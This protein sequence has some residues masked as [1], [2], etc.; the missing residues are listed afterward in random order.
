MMT[1][2]GKPGTAN[3]ARAGKRPR[4]S[5]SST[6]A[7]ERGKP[8]DVP[9]G[10]GG[11]R[12]IMGAFFSVFNRIEYGLDL[13]HAVDAERI[14]AQN[15]PKGPL[16]VEDAR[17]APAVLSELERRGHALDR[18]GE[19]DIRP[20]V[21]AAGFRTSEER[22][23]DAVS[24]PRTDAGSLAQRARRCRGRLGGRDGRGGRLHDALP[25]AHYVEIDGGRT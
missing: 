11:S 16:I 1:D 7:V 15:E 22:L 21:Q 14:D 17:I 19:Y 12:I 18:K 3:E 24:D 4:S 8:I 25:D 23:K 13:A 2:F 6:I 9:G 5:I 20:R 10:A